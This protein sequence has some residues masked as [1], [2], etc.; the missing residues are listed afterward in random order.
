MSDDWT[1]R[2]A[3][4]YARV[5]TALGITRDDGTPGDVDAVLTYLA[6]LQQRAARVHELE[7]ERKRLA[8]ALRK[9]RQI[10]K[11]LTML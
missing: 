6:T 3:D 9:Q 2:A 5:C 1:H 8:K 7:V 11:S 4:G 10:A